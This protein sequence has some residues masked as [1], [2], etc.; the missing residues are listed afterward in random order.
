M[1]VSIFGGC[2]EKPSF[3]EKTQFLAAKN[4]VSSSQNSDSDGTKILRNLAEKY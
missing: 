1:E 2:V 3:E 4:S